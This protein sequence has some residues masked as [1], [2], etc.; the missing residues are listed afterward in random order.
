MYVSNK[1][2]G[3]LVTIICL[4]TIN[5]TLCVINI[6]FVLNHVALHLW[7]HFSQVLSIISFSMSIQWLTT[8]I[9]V[10]SCTVYFYS[11]TYWVYTNNY[12]YLLTEELVLGMQ[13]I[14]QQY[15]VK[16]KSSLLII[17]RYI[18]SIM[19]MVSLVYW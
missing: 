16:G 19:W 13:Q 12:V 7:S 10:F 8:Y 18:S 5:N 4:F 15:H 1:E 14:R 3:E 9:I 6:F 11:R 17:H 2:W